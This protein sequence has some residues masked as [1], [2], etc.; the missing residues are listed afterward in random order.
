MDG[1]CVWPTMRFGVSR[2]LTRRL[3]KT[4]DARPSRIDLLTLG[5]S[6]VWAALTVGRAR[7]A[8]FSFLSSLSERV[9]ELYKDPCFDDL[10]QDL[11]N[12]FFG[13]FGESGG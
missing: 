2:A 7:F 6:D 10:L 1:W 9:G 12:Y 4:P 5:L 11:G 13:V 8:V 3:P